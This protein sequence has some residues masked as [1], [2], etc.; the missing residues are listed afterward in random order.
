MSVLRAR[1]GNVFVGFGSE[2][3]GAHFS[4]EL[5]PLDAGASASPDP[6]FGGIVL[7]GE[8]QPGARRVLNISV[9][10]PPLWC[11]CATST[12]APRFS[13]NERRR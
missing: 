13:K 4:L 3:A 10:T 1:P 7:R 2:S 8:R 9:A 11:V 12:R 6:A 5:S